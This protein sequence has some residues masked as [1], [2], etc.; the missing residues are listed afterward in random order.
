MSIYSWGDEGPRALQKEED[1]AEWEQ[2]YRT[3]VI[4]YFFTAVA[5]LPLFSAASAK[6]GHADSVIDISSMSG[7]TRSSQHHFAHNTSRAAA[8]QLTALLAQ[9]LRRPCINVRVNTEGSNELQKSNIPDYGAKKGIPA[10]C[11]GREEDMAQ[12]ALFLARN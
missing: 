4:G 12:A 7:I 11:P 9:E 6:P 2:V 8:I 10:N 1:Q 5:F 3:D